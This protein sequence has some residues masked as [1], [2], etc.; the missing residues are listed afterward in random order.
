MEAII[1]D[2]EQ[3]DAIANSLT[4]VQEKLSELIPHD[5]EKFVDN[6]EF[7]LMMRVSK[8]TAQSWRDEG[9]IAFS[10]IG[11]KIYY[12]IGDIE[13]LLTRNYQRAYNTNARVQLNPKVFKR[14]I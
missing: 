1:L 12:K 9:V 10:Q 11:H 5:K 8:R 14:T 4:D 2:K 7:L 13:D 6:Q 3:F